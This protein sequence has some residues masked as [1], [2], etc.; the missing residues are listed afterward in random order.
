MSEGH[1]KTTEV[2]ALGPAE[3]S[4]MDDPNVGAGTPETAP[5]EPVPET[6]ADR[7]RRLLRRDPGV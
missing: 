6:L 2:E 1:D 4:A 5:S 7:A 3:V